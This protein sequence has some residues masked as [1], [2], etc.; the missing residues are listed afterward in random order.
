MSDSSKIDC[1]EAVLSFDTTTYTQPSCVS[2]DTNG[3]IT[4]TGNDVGCESAS[5]LNFMIK[6]ENS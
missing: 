4:V 2:F 1:G 6:R 3:V 5:G